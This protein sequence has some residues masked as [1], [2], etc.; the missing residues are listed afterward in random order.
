MTL[1]ELR[2]M[3]RLAELKHFGAAAAA[4]HVSQPTLSVAIKK[5]E[6]FLGTTLF[7]RR[8]HQVLLTESGERL[9]PQARRILQETDLMIHMA[10]D[11]DERYQQSIR[12]GAILT[13]GPYIFP[14]LIQRI[15][16]Q[17][18]R[19]NLFL[20]EDFTNNLLIA[21]EQ[22]SLD[23]IILA[24]PVDERLY[25]VYPL[26]SEP[27]ELLLPAQHP[28]AQLEQIDLN[29]LDSS[30]LLM[31]AEGHCL[32]DQ[33]LTAC[34]NLQT[35]RNTSMRGNSLATLSHMIALGMGM[36]L[37]PSSAEKVLC[38]AHEGML[39]CRSIRPMISREIHLVSRRSD[40]RHRIHEQLQNQLKACRTPYMAIHS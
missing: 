18:L 23:A 8:K 36:T 39:V 2:Y 32:R 4:C 21:L 33:V 20:T 25:R 5:L 17:Q 1:T 30:Q 37:I 35:E 14:H 26:Y 16:T 12:L 19:L 13:V 29:M 38:Q 3:V 9:L 31:L 28:W 11:E 15:S 34:P 40:Q 24:T 10:H 27:L 7:E 6:D 22:G